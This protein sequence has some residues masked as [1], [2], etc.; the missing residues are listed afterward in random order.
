MVLQNPHNHPVHLCTKPTTRDK[1]KLVEAIDAAGKTGLTVWKFLP[2]Y[3]SASTTS[4]LYNGK[5]IAETSPVYMD[6]CRIH[7]AIHEEKMKDYPKGM[8][9]E[10]VSIV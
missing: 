9:W 6:Q 5:P 7:D 2:E 1:E 8:G 10:G 3:Q 4:M